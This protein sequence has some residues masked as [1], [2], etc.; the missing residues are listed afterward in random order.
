MTAIN[1]R[2]VKLGI[3]LK[4]LIKKQ[5]IKKKRMFLMKRK[6]KMFIMNMIV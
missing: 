1:S 2:I 3:K 4:K 5:S 6:K